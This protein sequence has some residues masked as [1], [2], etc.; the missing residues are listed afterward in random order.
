MN[1]VENINPASGLGASAS[2]GSGVEAMDLSK[3]DTGAL[4]LLGGEKGLGLIKAFGDSE[5]G[6]D[7]D[8][9]DKEKFLECVKHD[10]S[11]RADL[12][13]FADSAEGEPYKGLISKLFDLFP[14]IEDKS[15][16]AG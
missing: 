13:K 5:L 1:G 12:K 15:K 2:A 14:E 6:S 9:G 8:A 3:S 4:A 11:F 16:D 7:Y 10:P